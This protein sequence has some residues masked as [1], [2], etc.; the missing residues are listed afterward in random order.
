LATIRIVPQQPA[1]HPDFWPIWRDIVI[2]PIRADRPRLRRRA[3]WRPPRRGV[4]AAFVLVGPASSRLSASAVRADP[5]A[6]WRQLPAP[7]R[8]HYGRTICLHGRRAPASR[9]SRSGFP[10]FRHDLEPEYGRVHCELFG[11]DLDA[12]ASSTIAEVQQR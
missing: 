9:S 6:Y 10:P 5:W 11:L 4:G 8:P 1:D 3:L 12:A 7:V 2:A